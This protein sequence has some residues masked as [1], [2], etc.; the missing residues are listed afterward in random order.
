MPR[1]R[2]QAIEGRV[3]TEVST[4][5]GEGMAEEGTWLTE[6]VFQA[7]ICA[8]ETEDSILSPYCTGGKTKVSQQLRVL[9]SNENSRFQ[10]LVT[11]G[12]AKK[13]DV[14]CQTI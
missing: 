4:M 10:R 12:R 2:N 5:Y 1:C 11:S 6:P 13:N 9:Y 14:L 3:S 7:G 8:G